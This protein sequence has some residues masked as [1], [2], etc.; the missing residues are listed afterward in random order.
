MEVTYDLFSKRCESTTSRKGEYKTCISSE[1]MKILDSTV[2]W[3]LK[4]YGKFTIDR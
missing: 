3:Y 1:P 4:I 2:A